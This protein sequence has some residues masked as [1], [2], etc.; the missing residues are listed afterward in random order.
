MKKSP[1]NTTLS[2][3]ANQVYLCASDNNR[4]CKTLCNAV[5]SRFPDH[6]NPASKFYFFHILTYVCR[7]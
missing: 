2:I 7:D 4:S 5:A 1:R 6:G 3:Q